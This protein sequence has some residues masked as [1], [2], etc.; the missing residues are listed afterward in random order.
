MSLW[1]RVQ[2]LP[3]G[4]AH[5]QMR[6]VY[7]THFP[8][9][10]RHYFA[11]WI[12]QQEWQNIDEDDPKY[13]EYAKQLLEQLTMKI[14]EKAAE[15]AGSDMYPI[16]LKLNEIA[17]TFREM[18]GPNP[19]NLVQVVK[20]CLTMESSLVHLHESGQSGGQQDT[21]R[22]LGQQLEQLTKYT[23]DTDKDLRELQNKQEQFIIHYQESVRINTQLSNIPAGPQRQEMEIRLR[24][25]K[26]K[27]EIDLSRMAQE[28]LNLR[29]ALADKHEAT[30]KQLQ[31]VQNKVLEEELIKWKRHQQLAGNGAPF[32]CNLDQLQSWC[33]SLADIIWSNRQQIKQVE[34]LRAHLPIDIPPHV[35]DLLPNLNTTIT[36]LL[37]SLVT[38]TF[39][40][41]KQP[42]QV[43]KTQAR[44]QSNVRL[45]VG[46]NLNVHMNPPAVKAS[47]INEEQAKAL[48]RN[49]SNI[50]G[51][52]SGEI[53]N[54]QGTMEYN[55]A[56]QQLS[57]AFRNMSLRRIKRADRRGT[58]A[59]TEEKFSILF[60]SSFTVGAGELVFKV[61]T[62][63]LPV[64]VIVHGNQECN[65]MATVL[66]DNAF[67]EPGRIPF[68][69]PEKVKYSQLTQMINTKFTSQTG[70][71]ITP[72]GFH[73]LAQKLLP[74]VHVDDYSNQLISWSQFNKEQVPTK[75]F[76]FWEWIYN[77]IKLT[78]EYLKG[79]WNDNLVLGFVSRERAAELLMQQKCGTFLLR[80]SE[81]S[82]GGVT[83]AWVAD[84]PQTS[85]KKV[86]NLAPFAAKDF[87]IRSLAD[88]ISDLPTLST[89][90]PNIPKLD[91]FGKYC[92]NPTN[93]S[94]LTNEG[95]VG[96]D[97]RAVIPGWPAGAEGMLDPQAYDNPS[98][99]Q[100][101]IPTD[102]HNIDEVQ[103]DDMLSFG[104]YD[105][106]TFI[107]NVTMNQILNN[108]A[109]SP[110]TPNLGNF[111]NF[112]NLN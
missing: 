71:P 72:E 88:R 101:H 92:S 34:S 87:A 38:S 58:E 15:F 79:P 21:A 27:I 73:Y 90:F 2:Q 63:S 16:K 100:S 47:I 82:L 110:H 80:F 89:L 42:P 33:E 24:N 26:K 65:A 91:C 94:E 106:D 102:D 31:Q 95:Y 41:E 93:A 60:Q 9:E 86:W 48:L 109:M 22:I 70:S 51:E 84:D 8:M 108:N 103:M 98:S 7:G 36:G 112:Q 111:P 78:K 104:D 17:S 107:N 44:F 25:E 97:L 75:A 30:F 49:D 83:I 19:L 3:P 54:S 4:G 55:Q 64:A 10:V 23:Q 74:G 62:L 32:D 53:L 13:E 81:G 18:Y 96:L 37:S 50:S 61:W 85:E 52:N 12:E 20:K 43:L 59:V 77:I 68:A 76:T 69:V 57:I 56:T 6:N 66:W 35:P 40:I 1:G 105:Q 14:E 45:L 67:A 46:G 11:E 29:I 28:L 5:Q 39:I 99:V